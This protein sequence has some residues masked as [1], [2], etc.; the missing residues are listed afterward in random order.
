MP[1]PPSEP[2]ATFDKR[3]RRLLRGF[4]LRAVGGAVLVLAFI[5]A[6]AIIWFLSSQTS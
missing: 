1:Q 2:I 3:R 5:I 4:T 6:A